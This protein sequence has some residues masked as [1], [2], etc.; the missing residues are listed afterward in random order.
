MSRVVVA[1]V[2][3]VRI[4]HSV[5]AFPVPF[6]PSDSRTGGIS[7]RLASTGWTAVRTLQRLG[8]RVAFATYVGADPLGLL[9]DRA[10][11]E[12]GLYGPAV[13]VCDAQP[14]T[15][16]LYDD[17]GLR[18]S[19]RDLRATP[20]L[21]YPPD[22]FGSI[23]DSDGGCDMALLNNIGFTRPLIPV[24][25]ARGVPFATDLHLVADAR[26]PHNREWMCAAHLLACS[27]ERLPMPPESWVRELWRRFGTELVLVGCGATGAVLGVRSPRGIWRIDPTTPRGVR[28]PSGAGDTLLASFVHHLALGDPV[29]AARHAV[30]TAGWKVGG[31]PDEPPG[32]DADDLARLRARHGLPTAHR[33]A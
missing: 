5:P 4:A 13:Q 17:T 7:V 31:A 22:V 10:L 23:L 33:L 14:R 15:V 32:V 25:V 9:A 24:A 1:G 29:A 21:R 16:V 18:A 12:H 3:S 11:R 26:S 27:H 30:L 6:V 28:Y 19:T 20:G 2:A 8:S